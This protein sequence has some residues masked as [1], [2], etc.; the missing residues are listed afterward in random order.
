MFKNRFVPGLRPLWLIALWG[1]FAVRPCQAVQAN[2]KGF[3][4]RYCFECHDSDAKKGGLDLSA[5]QFELKNST[6]FAAWVTV[7]DRVANGEM[8]PKKKTRPDVADL[9]AFTNYLS[10]ALLLADRAKVTK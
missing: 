7:A 4:E 9:K 5:L 10:S 6:N 2:V 1:M 3:V 8:P